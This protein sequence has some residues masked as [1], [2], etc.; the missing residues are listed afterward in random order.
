MVHRGVQYTRAIGAYY[1]KFG[2]YP[3]RLEDLENTNNLR[4]LRKRYKDPENKNQ[5]FK[6]LHFG[7]VKLGFG[8]GSIPGATSVSAM[9]SQGSGGSAF[10]GGSSFGGSSFGGSTFGGSSLGSSGFGG[11]GVNQSGVFA[12]S[13][14]FGG[15]QNSA[16]GGNQNSAFGGNQS[17]AFGGNSNSAFGGNSQ[18]SGQNTN[19]GTDSTQTNGQPGDSNA[20]QNSSAQG[21]TNA[22]GS[23][24]QVF[25]GGPIV[26][27]SSNNSKDTTIREYNHKKKY[28]EWQF[29]YDPSLD[30]RVLISTPYQP[31]LAFGGGNVNL[32][33]QPGQ[34]GQ[35]G[36]GTSNSSPFGSSSFGSSSFGSSSFGSGSTFNSNMNSNPGMGATPPP[37]NPPQQQ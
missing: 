9:A 12:Q 11:Q 4:F 20:N 24:Q 18:T 25:G 36:T 3:T 23:Q 16:F 19:S 17:S 34:P 2:R 14:A 22:S 15:N 13:S 28:N 1:K 33:G 29:V 10:G 7:E 8:G 6:L 37:S 31:A 32:N 26:G 21:A 30:T 5:D 35:P 27:V